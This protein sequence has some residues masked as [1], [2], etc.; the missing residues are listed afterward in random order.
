MSVD[1]LPGSW[2]RRTWYAHG[3]FDIGHNICD[4]QYYLMVRTVG[5][6]IVCLEDGVLLLPG[7]AVVLGR[8]QEPSTRR[9]Y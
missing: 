8:G 3:K 6:W 2:C 9:I 4:I 5:V 1:S 7:V